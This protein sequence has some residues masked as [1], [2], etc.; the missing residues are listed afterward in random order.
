[1]GFPLMTLGILSGALWAQKVWGAE[2]WTSDVKIL[3]SFLTWF[4]Y[5]FLIHYRFIAGWRG[6]KAAYLAI[7][8]F[9]G[10][11]LTFVVADMF[12]GLHTFN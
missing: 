4:I 3:L 6:K 12:T 8:G 1:V 2:K 11:F 5:L 10:V 7:A 9:V